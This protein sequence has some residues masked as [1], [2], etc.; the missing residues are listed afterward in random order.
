MYSSFW[1]LGQ[2][3]NVTYNTHNQS[4][5]LPVNLTIKRWCYLLFFLTKLLQFFFFTD[6]LLNKR[7]IKKFNINFFP[8]QILFLS[9]VDFLLFLFA[10]NPPF[11]LNLEI[12][13]FFFINLNT[14]FFFFLST[15]LFCQNNII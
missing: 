3:Y 14:Q 6:F 7:I 12:F 11:K 15:F 9:C 13:Y 1:Q 2:Q 4:G 8:R 10:Y 5:L